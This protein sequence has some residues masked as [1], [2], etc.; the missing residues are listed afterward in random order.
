M[1]DRQRQMA[2]KASMF[3]CPITR[4]PTE[5]AYGVSSILDQERFGEAAFAAIEDAT[6]NS[7][8][9]RLDA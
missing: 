9:F 7:R 5:A 1:T 2:M 6:I 8:P 3:L 4:P